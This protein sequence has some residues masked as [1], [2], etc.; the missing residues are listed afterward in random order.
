MTDRNWEGAV[1]TEAGR[2]HHRTVGPHR[3]WSDGQSEWC[4]P[5]DPCSWCREHQGEVQVWLPAE[6][7]PEHEALVERL[8]LVM[9]EARQAYNRPGFS[10]YRTAVHFQVAA[11]LAALRE[12]M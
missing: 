5:D 11:V 8:A 2:D 3:A 10:T 1:D 9:V 7:T 12:E 6:G 4:Y